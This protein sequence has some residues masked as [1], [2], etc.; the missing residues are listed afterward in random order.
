MN[1]LPHLVLSSIALLLNIGA[2]LTLECK[3]VGAARFLIGL[4]LAIALCFF[5]LFLVLFL[6]SSTS[7]PYWIGKALA[8]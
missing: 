2:I 4:Q 1:F 3:R 8:K 5:L 7:A 6:Y